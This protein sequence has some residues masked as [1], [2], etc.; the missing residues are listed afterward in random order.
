[1][2]DRARSLS[3]MPIRRDASTS[4][5]RSPSIDIL[6]KSLDAAGVNRRTFV[7][8]TGLS[9]EYVS[10]IFNSK[11]KFP[12]VRETLERFAEVAKID[13]AR[14][15]HLSR[16]GIVDQCEQQM[17]E[18]CIFVAALRSVGERG[19]KRLFKA[20]GKT[21]HDTRSQTGRPGHTGRLPGGVP[22]KGRRQTMVYAAE[23]N[24]E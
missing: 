24:R 21:G 17:F 4:R 19:M 2:S 23:L 18:R 12:A 7:N 5:P 1:M 11:V 20:L 8:E 13:P 15:H 10:R 3:R 16:V 22:V 14:L 6:K 9:Y